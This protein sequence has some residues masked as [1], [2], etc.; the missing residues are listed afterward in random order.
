MC[1][2]RHVMLKGARKGS[3]CG[4]KVLP[5]KRWCR[6]HVRDDNRSI[7]NSLEALRKL[8]LQISPHADYGIIAS[9]D[10]NN[11]VVKK[12][13]NDRILD[14]WRY[15]I[16]NNKYL[17]YEGVATPV[18]VIH[19]KLSNNVVIPQVLNNRWL[20]EK[21]LGKGGFGTV[22]QCRDR[23]NP[24]DTFAV[25]LEPYN[26]KT[27]VTETG[28]FRDLAT[29][30]FVPRVFEIGNHEDKI[31]FIVM[32][33]LQPFVFEFGRLG[34]MIDALADFAAAGWSHGDVKF[35]NFLSRVNGDPVIIDFGLSKRVGFS[36][37]A[38]LG[39]TVLFMSTGAH[40]GKC[41]YKNDMESLLY[42]ILN[43]S[44][45]L[46]WASVDVNVKTFAGLD[47][48]LKLK[49]ILEKLLIE[50]RSSLT[51]FSRRLETFAITIV[52]CGQ[53]E[54]PDY[55]SIKKQMLNK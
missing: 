8:C 55:D 35:A 47:N 26:T 3:F 15:K 43:I 21:K 33:K 38:A 45:G 37:G 41:L 1:V 6:L 18:R 42:C 25:K 34:Q 16:I 39:G 4:K 54:M 46:P 23:L 52:K 5:E 51:K 40:K 17:K 50:R 27:F 29:S 44:F 10:S 24:D 48:V 20:L 32:E 13:V 22:F 12:I 30:P 7:N 2:C 19:D 36:R 28:V 49:L 14:A 9:N 31:S 11:P 53:D